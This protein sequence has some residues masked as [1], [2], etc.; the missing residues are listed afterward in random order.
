MRLLTIA[1]SLFL[2]QHES[3]AFGPS[4]V[5]IQTR[6]M[7]GQALY[8]G[9]MIESGTVTKEDGDDEEKASKV[10]DEKAKEK[11]EKRDL[12]IEALVEE[13]SEGKNLLDEGDE[14]GNISDDLVVDDEELDE[15]SLLDIDMMQKAIQMAQSR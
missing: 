1:L 12:D 7:Q 14:E 6:Q 9:T 13:V 3:E 2:L 5:R 4:A 11:K 8:A 15:Q 10:K